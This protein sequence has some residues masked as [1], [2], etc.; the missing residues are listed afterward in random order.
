MIHQ[1]LMQ[2][3]ILSAGMALAIGAVADTLM[4][5]LLRVAG[6][7]AAP[8][9][10]RGPGDEVETG[11]VWIAN[12]ERRTAS[13]LTS[14]GGYRSPV[15]SPVDGSVYALKGDTIVR[16]AASNGK[17]AVVQKVTGVLK[18]VGFEGKNGDEIIVLVDAGTAGSP[19]GVVSLT[20][21]KMTPLPYNANSEDQR[22]MLAQIRAPDRVY[23]DTRVYTKT[24]SK[25]GLSR[26]IEWTDV[27]LKRG[28]TEP[29]NISACDGV[30]CGQPALSPDGRRL[31]FLK[32]DG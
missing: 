1:R 6:L 13:A 5:K 7:T 16:F 31:A 18:L 4:D 25:R 15:F 26:A 23:G 22:R 2:S 12:L 32:T 29:R 8:A 28:D 14:D 24:E 30:S 9:Q 3:V 27:Y 10:L 19:L 11:N 17:T 20:S 21:G